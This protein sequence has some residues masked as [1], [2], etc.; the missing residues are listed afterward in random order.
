[1]LKEGGSCNPG[2]LAGGS[3]ASFG[4]SAEA[5]KKSIQAQAERMSAHLGHV[6]CVPHRV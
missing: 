3:S 1:M 5:P 6:R 2:V 4:Y